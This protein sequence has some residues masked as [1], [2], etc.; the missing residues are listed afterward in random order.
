MSKW[1]NYEYKARPNP[2]ANRPRT[3]DRPQHKE[4]IKAL[5]IAVDRGRYTTVISTDSKDEHEVTAMRAKELRKEAIVP[6]D[7]V[8]LVGD[9]SGTEGSL[10]RI[11]RIEQRRNF[12]RRSGDDTDKQER[13]LVANVDNLLIVTAAAEPEP[14]TG[15]IDRMIVAAIAAEIK[16]SLCVT[17]TDLATATALREHY[18]PLGVKVFESFMHDGKVNADS[19]KKLKDVL[20]GKV[21]VLAG[22]SGVGKSTLTNTLSGSD[23][24][25][26]H[27]NETTGRGRHTTS[28]TLAVQ[29]KNGGWLI[30]TPGIRSFGL[31]HVNRDDILNGFP[32]I[33]QATTECEK[34]CLHNAEATNC[35]ID[36]LL[37]KSPEDAR[38][39]SRV[40]SLRRLLK[41]L[42]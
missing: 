7:I 36:T 10:A 2:K 3:K 31:A 16:P 22:H 15:L 14:R 33:L 41:N 37:S 18:E 1:D 40:D 39:A 19:L 4:A 6:G 28:S 34:G 26:G 30:D 38:L 8:A 24:S 11:V 23:R 42:S 35:G 32:E 29:L 27:V 13:I 20:Q 5:V 25:V 21:S 9:T 17:K 12:L